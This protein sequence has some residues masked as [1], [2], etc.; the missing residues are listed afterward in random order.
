VAHAPSAS[1]EEAF[2]RYSEGDFERSREI[3]VELLQA[4]PE[5]P[6]LLRLAGK[7]GVELGAADAVEQL[8]LAAGIDP[9]NADIW[10]DLADALLSEGRID[11][12]AAAI[13]KAVERRPGDPASLVDLAH[14]LHA[15]GHPEAA[16]ATLERALEA[17]PGNVPALHGL[18]G[19]HRAAGRLDDALAAGR[20]LVAHSPRDA[21]SALDVAELA[22][23]VGRLD[24]AHDAF[25]HVRDV[26]DEPEHEVYALH[27]MIETE[28]RRER[29]RAALDLAVDATR[30]DRLGRTTDV[31]SYVVAHVF[32]AGD[33]PAPSRA[34][35]DEALAASRREH[36]RLHDAVGF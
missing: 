6:S 4:S 15:M 25:R 12:A 28:L 35:V 3:V 36:R 9:E 27:G 21:A 31:L 13:E 10:R 14:I 5:D 11:D 29:W 23:D 32:G 33:R 34:A 2:A 17:E 1:Y 8:E 7:A 24:E 16:I 20:E 19:M 18:L 26:D 30:V 22:L